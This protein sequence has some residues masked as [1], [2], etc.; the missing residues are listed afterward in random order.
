MAI[1]ILE[2][3]T[4]CIC[5]ELGDIGAWP[6]SG[7]F[8][9]DTRFLS[10]LKLT[11]NGHR[12]LILSSDKVDYF[13]AAFYLR[14]QP[15][16][17][18]EHDE[19]SITRE[20]FVGEAMQDRLL[21]QNQGMRSI[22]FD[23]SLEVATDFADIFAVKDYDF[24]LGDPESAEP[25][26]PAAAVRFE[27]EDNQFVLA[28]GSGFPA[29]TQVILSRPGEIVAEGKITY[30]IEL[31]PRERWDLRI[32]VVPAPEGEHVVARLA[33]RRFGDEI[34]RVRESLAAWQLR[35]PQLRAS[36]DDLAYSFGRSV[37]D[38]A[39]LRMRGQDVGAGKLPAAGMPWFMTVFG[40][41][42]IIT[43]LQTLLF[44]PELAMTALHA[45]RDLQSTVDDPARDAEPGK[46]VHEVRRGKAARTWH[47][48]YYG[49]VDATPLYLILLSEVWRWTDDA[50]LV[51]DFRESAIQALDWIAKRGDLDGDGFVEYLKRSPRGLDNQSWKDSYD[52]QRFADG[53][54]AE[55]PIAPCEVQGYVYDAK[56]R[57]AELAREVWRDRELA[58]RLE[59]EADELHQRFNETFWIPE[60][61]GYYA[62]ALDRDKKLVDSLS[63]NVG[64]LLWSGIVPPERVDAVVD[65]LMGDS[66]WSGWGVRTM[67]TADRGYNPL[68]YHNGTVWPH[69][70]SLI[71][72][73]LARNARWPEAHRII[74]QMLTAARHFDYQLP[75]VFAGMP[76]AETRF[77]IAYPTA[78]RPQAWA[79]G[80]PVLLLQLLL[81]LEPDPRQSTLET[82]APQELPAWAGSL[83]LSGVRAFDRHWDIR[84]QEGWVQVSAA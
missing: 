45:L 49:T 78:A 16:G 73:G 13:S 40:R 39:S 21:V 69:D 17:G 56:R 71:A 19:V 80:T 51:H 82:V 61:N 75:E 4:F 42:T 26:P 20:R 36:W 70:N 79:A 38:L 65:Q 12:P 74:R 14:N 48:A 28:D 35:V 3:S 23:L 50:G 62:L 58:E 8:A 81:G 59:R 15:V 31:E 77:P 5:D 46:I 84:L 57:T 10:M 52:S 25:L 68:A 9:E 54:F 60:R 37:S 32:D 1:T 63:S 7:L 11:V 34:A 76:R 72:W 83:R 27:E 47:A 64:H 43:C 67:S 30:R 33:E 2:G 44:G 53:Q 55:P 6:T 22:A 66:L 18:L 29:H 41:D 24:A